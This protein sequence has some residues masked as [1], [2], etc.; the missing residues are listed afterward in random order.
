MVAAGSAAM[1]A[2][3]V[4]DITALVAA[5]AIFL[6]AGLAWMGGTLVRLTGSV[7]GWT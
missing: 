4:P 5:G 7:E 1:V 3:S 6:F 2:G